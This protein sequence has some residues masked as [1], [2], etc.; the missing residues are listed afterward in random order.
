MKRHTEVKVEEVPVEDKLKFYPYLLLADDSDELVRDYLFEGD[1]YS[2]KYGNHIA[3]VILMLLSSENVVE[4][5]NMA[6]DD[7]YRGIGIGKTV[8]NQITEMYRMKGMLKVI[9]G[10]ANSSIGNLAFYQKAGFRMTGIRKDFFKRY[11]DP[12][13]EDGIRALD[14]VM[15]EMV[16]RK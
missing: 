15:F 7:A 10:T 11:P 8:L 2:I 13:F 9:V 14:M 5:K 1:M 6:L 16:L 4:I 12:I 3:G